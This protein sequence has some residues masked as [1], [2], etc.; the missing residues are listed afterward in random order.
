MR[1]RSPRILF[2][3]TAGLALFILLVERR[4]ESPAERAARTGRAF[5]IPMAQ[6]RAVEIERAGV[7]IE[8]ERTDDEG[9]VLIRPLRARADDAAVQRL[10]HGLEQ[11][12]RKAR[13]TEREMAASGATWA[14]YGLDRPA[15]RIRLR[16]NGEIWSLDVGSL[17]ATA[18]G[19]YVRPGG[20]ATALRTET[21]LLAWI[22]SEPA[23][24]RD[25]RV[26]RASPADIERMELIRPDGFVR[27]GR[28]DPP[29]WAMLQPTPSRADAKEVES[30]L[31]RF[32]GL[33]IEAFAPDAGEEAPGYGFEESG[34]E[35]V[36][37]GRRLRDAVKR[38]RL[39]RPDPDRP[40][41]IFA[42]F[43]HDPAVFLIPAEAMG[44]IQTPSADL[45][46]RRLTPLRPGDIEHFRIRWGDRVIEFRKEAGAWSL[47][48]PIRALAEADRVGMIIEAWADARIEAFLDPPVPE[49]WE[50]DWDEPLGS[51]VFGRTPDG[52]DGLRL[53]VHRRPM[54]DGR[55]V[56]RAEGEPSLLA[57]HPDLAATLSL[58]PI[59][60]RDLTVL[61]LEPGTIQ[62]LVLNR[63]GGEW[64]AA[65]GEGDAWQAPDGRLDRAILG[66]LLAELSN[67]RAVSWVRHA[68]SDPS[69]FGLDEPFA[70][71]TLRHT[72]EEGYA[73]TLLL[74]RDA[75]LGRYAVIRGRETV[76]LLGADAVEALTTPFVERQDP[77]RE[78]A[79]PGGEAG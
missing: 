74:G 72:G 17:T 64:R 47:T 77:A 38:L 70:E 51:L 8:C 9:W 16:A 3:L 55:L 5:R 2:L 49:E 41:R 53:A 7:L 35:L 62:S 31:E 60:F 40:D 39:G 14:D 79:P 45:R 68:P 50:G 11:L 67:L 59:L 43:R 30:L 22:P 27:L 56:V 61:K 24:W 34:A 48:A 20:Q 1:S 52:T 36:L 42:G 71:L 19:V 75:G 4:L 73:H 28:S 44:W 76:F 29:G 54:P 18:D 10:L 37:E 6:V 66:R 78:E 58:D 32:L 65:R 15:A 13:V 26:F 63:A 33:R 23:D 69:A 12:S 46:S 57:I 25:R 21:N